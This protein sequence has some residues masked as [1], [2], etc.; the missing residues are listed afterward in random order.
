MLH[1][2][3]VTKAWEEANIFGIMCLQLQFIILYLNA[4]LVTSLKIYGSVF[5]GLE[6]LWEIY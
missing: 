3:M 2:I 4:I 5:V 1:I 6:G